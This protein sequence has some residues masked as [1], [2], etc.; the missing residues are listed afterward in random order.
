MPMAILLELVSGVAGALLVLT[1]VAAGS[2]RSWAVLT[3]IGQPSR[4][5]DRVRLRARRY[6]DDTYCLHR[7]RLGDQLNFVPRLVIRSTVFLLGVVPLMVL[8]HRTEAGPGIAWAAVLI[9]EIA[10]C[11]YLAHYCVKH[12]DEIPTRSARR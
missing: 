7:S 1:G 2:L 10:G 4:M 12:E 9:Y 3:A 8:L 6:T 11:C 5:V